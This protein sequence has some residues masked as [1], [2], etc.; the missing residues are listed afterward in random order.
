MKKK[1]LALAFAGAS[2]GLFA[3]APS[4][5]AAHYCVEDGKGDVHQTNGNGNRGG[6]GWRNAS[7][8]Q[9]RSPATFDCGAGNPPPARVNGR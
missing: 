6:E 1:L 2:L 8:G 4:A 3:G 5:N 9:E 7:P